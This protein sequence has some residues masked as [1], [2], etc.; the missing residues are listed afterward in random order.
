MPDTKKLRNRIRS[1][2]STLHLTHAMELVASSKIRKANQRMEAS[3]DHAAAFRAAMDILA[4]SGSCAE[5]VWMRGAREEGAEPKTLLVVIAGDRGL[6]GGYNANIFRF[7]RDWPGAEIIPVGKRACER[8]NPGGTRLLAEPFSAADANAM[9]ETLCAAFSEG[10]ADRVGILYTELTSMM[11]Q[12]PKLRWILPLTAPEGVKPADMIF[13]P[14]EREILETAVPAYVA[15][16]L[17]ACVRESFASEVASRR[18]AMDAAGKNARE[19]IDDL[20][21]QYNRARQGAITQEITEIVA[22]GNA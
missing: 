17:M 6:A 22:G 21:L 14:D 10:R 5:S 16:E 12:T 20:Q 1:V 2:N 18:N 3:G 13:E 4:A 7:L 19:M 8:F 11:S 9:A 15:G